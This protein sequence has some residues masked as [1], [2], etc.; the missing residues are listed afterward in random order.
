MTGE[1]WL[2]LALTGVGGMLSGWGAVRQWRR[3]RLIEDTPTSKVR[4]AAQGYVELCGFA[5]PVEEIQLQSPLTG[6]P[7]IWFEYSIERYERRGKSSSWKVLERGS[8]EQ[9]FVLD[10]G[11]GHCLVH[12]RHAEV[13]CQSRKRWY[14]RQRHPR[15][16]PTGG[17]LFSALTGARYRYT[18]RRI[19]A[20][21]WLYTLG[22][23]ETIHAP[24]GA[25][26]QQERAR[27]LLLEWKRDREQLLARFDAN[28]DGEIDLQE[29]E[30]A[31]QTAAREAHYHVLREP[32]DEP[33]H[34]LSRPPQRS[35]PYVIATRDPE[36]LSRTFRWWA[37]GLSVLALGLA[38]GMIW[39]LTGGQ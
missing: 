3:A 4:S 22:W 21:E 30:R 9:P 32:D 14:G 8:S 2:A 13:V 19:C 23:F 35:H 6:I 17:G 34:T 25:L 37:A 31:R 33:V 36:Y 10:D 7:C 11:S 26:R 5:R 16:A 12:P 28:G 38:G 20:D 29:W 39:L 24:S 27:Q 18:E 15:G 1:W